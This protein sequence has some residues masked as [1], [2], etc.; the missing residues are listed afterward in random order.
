MANIYIRL[1]LPYFN[2]CI[3]TNGSTMTFIY[4]FLHH[5]GS[6]SG[7]NENVWHQLTLP[8]QWLVVMVQMKN[9]VIYYDKSL[10]EGGYIA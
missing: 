5:M 7:I 1:H 4:H 6:F 8:Q 3:E 2:T 10:Q 9:S